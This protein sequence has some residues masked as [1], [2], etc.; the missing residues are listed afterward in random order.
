M[1]KTLSSM[2]SLPTRPTT[3][4]HNHCTFSSLSTVSVVLVSIFHDLFWLLKLHHVTTKI[5]VCNSVLLKKLEKSCLHLKP[6]TNFW[7]PRDGLHHALFPGCKT[8]NLVKLILQGFQLVCP[9]FP[10]WPYHCSTYLASL[11]HF[12]KL[13]DFKKLKNLIT[14]INM[15]NDLN[16][17]DQRV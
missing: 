17:T 13:S 2:F 5:Q 12:Y 3:P 11:K 4:Q 10:N 1:F 15:R 16:P 7:P 6:D 14:E 8:T 9:V